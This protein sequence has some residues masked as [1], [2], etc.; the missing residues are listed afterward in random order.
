M[1][2]SSTTPFSVIVCILHLSTCKGSNSSLRTA[3]IPY[4]C[5]CPRQESEHLLLLLPWTTAIGPP[6]T[7]KDFKFVEFSLDYQT[8]RPQFTAEFKGV[9]IIDSVKETYSN[10]FV[11]DYPY[12]KEGYIKISLGE[13]LKPTSKKEED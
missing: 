9:E 10:K 1:A 11:V 7:V 4:T 13:V 2:L 8:N 6:L 12:T 5:T 3:S